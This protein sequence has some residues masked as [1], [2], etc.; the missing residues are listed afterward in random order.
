LQAEVTFVFAQALRLV[1]HYNALLFPFRNSAGGTGSDAGRLGAVI[2][3][4]ALV[5]SIFIVL[6]S[7]KLLLQQLLITT[8]IFFFINIIF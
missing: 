1:D 5:V 4:T 2:A 3:I 7:I 6:K 8:L